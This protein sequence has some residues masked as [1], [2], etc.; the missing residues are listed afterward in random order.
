MG[1]V[2]AAISAQRW[3]AQRRRRQK[4][5]GKRGVVWLVRGMA[6]PHHSA[7]LQRAGAEL[8]AGHRRSLAMDSSPTRQPASP[9]V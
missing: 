1:G 4:L 7:V 5:L 8:A 2:E 9:R 6:V 3:A